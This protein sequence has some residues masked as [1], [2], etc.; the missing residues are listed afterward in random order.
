M[1]A[2]GWPAHRGSM[3]PSR[4]AVSRDRPE[5][6]LVGSSVPAVVLE[7][8]ALLMPEVDDDDPTQTARVV[9][10]TR[11]RVISRDDMQIEY[12][13]DPYIQPIPVS[14]IAQLA[15]LL[16]IHTGGFA[17][18][19]TH[20]VLK[21][22]DLFKVLLQHQAMN[23]DRPSVFA[24]DPARQ[25][26]LLSVMMPFDAGFTPVYEAIR[27]G[28]VAASYECHRADDIWL[29]PHIMQTI[30]SLICRS[31]IVVADCTNRNPNVF[32]EAG[33]A[34]T[35]GRDVILIAQSI[36]DVPFDLRALHVLLYLPNGEGLARLTADVTARMAAII[37]RHG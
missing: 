1:A 10:I 7:Y 28:A 36:N 23:A 8:P 27:A 13:E 6:N 4:Y 17:L 2:G 5:F 26:N 25:S 14:K 24:L 30:V 19:H 21:D 31:N 18:Q 11:A 9:T 20:W 34:H 15:P 29:H 12:V 22:T 33:I 3:L 32:Y 16:D 35:L 37:A